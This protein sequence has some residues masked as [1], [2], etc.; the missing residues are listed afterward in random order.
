MTWQHNTMPPFCRMDG[1]QNRGA[2]RAFTLVELLVCISIIALLVGILMPALAAARQS[3]RMMSELAASRTLG[4]AYIGYAL[5]RDGDL[6]PGY[7]AAADAQGTDEEGRAINGEPAKRYPW[8]LVSYIDHGL[9]GSIFVNGHQDT[10][11]HQVN[12]QPEASQL[13]MWQYLVSL[14]PSFGLNHFYLGGDRETPANNGPGWLRS[15]DAAVEPSR[16]IVF[17]SSRMNSSEPGK[18]IHGFFKITAPQGT[19]S[20]W[21]VTYDP[22]G[23]PSFWGY[24]DPRWNDRAVFAHLDGHSETLNTDQMR[25]MT[26]WSNRAAELNDPDWSP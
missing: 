8:R 20:P 11:Q 19:P 9:E 10:I 24:V 23:D 1:D 14:Q 22:D 12:Q 25:D 13:F 4:Q 18:F 3:A 16:M 26:R 17:G 2:P 5:D 7:V 6:L 21:A 15:I